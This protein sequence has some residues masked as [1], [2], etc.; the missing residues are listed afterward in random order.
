MARY[1]GKILMIDDEQALLKLSSSILRREGFAVETRSDARE[2]LAL[3]QNES[4]D[5]ILLDL[6]MPAMSGLEFLRNFNV[7]ER[8]EEVLILTAYAE[9]Q[10]AVETVKLG[11]YGYLAKPFNAE[12]IL[13]HIN[14]I[15]E[16]QKLRAENERLRQAQGA[17]LGMV[18]EDEQMRQIYRMVQDVAATPLPVLICGESGTGKELV[19]AAIHR[20]SDL[21]ARPFVR[22]N[23]AALNPG[24]LESELFGHVKGA[25]TGA[26]RDRKGRFME[27]D[28]GTLFLDEIGDMEV[29]L[30]T[31][32]LRVLQEGEF[33]PVGSTRTHQVDV[34]VISATN[35]DLD[36]AMASG[37]FREDLFYRLN[38]VTIEVPPLR[39]RKADIPL[40]CQAFIDKMSERLNTQV[41]RVGA[42]A[43]ARLESHDWPGNVRELE[44]AILR[45]MALA[46]GEEITVADLPANLTE[47]IAEE[48][49][50]E[51]V[52]FHDAREHFEE[53]FIR[54]A[55]AATRGNISQAAERI[56]LGRRNLQRKIKQFDIDV[57]Q[58]SR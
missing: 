14:N 37:R 56:Q 15:R 10:S 22:C 29:G 17:G 39:Q 45:S 36:R 13:N 4:F 53:Q 5:I 1:D 11:A 38:A 42:E 18:G 48:T 32:L 44:N 6:H 52:L 3:L 19:A 51:E 24:V 20:A 27:A 49:P 35:Q 46:K 34:R 30:Q 25:F 41:Q 50:E 55:L 58:Y 33:E 47:R 40:L 54:N 31:R 12:E 16:L 8:P 57:S 23:C 28:G 26:V 2:A 9:V 7:R 43:L 21:A